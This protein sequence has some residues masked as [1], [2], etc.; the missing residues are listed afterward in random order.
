MQIFNIIAMAIASPVHTD[1]VEE[2]VASIHLPAGCKKRDFACK[3]P[4]ESVDPRE[5]SNTDRHGDKKT[6][7][8][9]ASLAPQ[10]HAVPPSHH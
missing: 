8:L 2:G 1:E 9:F 7:G 10:A 3:L 5:Q 4:C 6:Y